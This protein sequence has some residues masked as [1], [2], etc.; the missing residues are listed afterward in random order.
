MTDQLYLYYHSV[1][2]NSLLETLRAIRLNSSQTATMLV[3]NLL[4]RTRGGVPFEYAFLEWWNAPAQCLT[5]ADALD[6]M[7]GKD[8]MD[9]LSGSLFGQQAEVRFRL[10]PY[11]P[12]ENHNK[13]SF[14]LA[15]IS[16]VPLQGGQSW[17]DDADALQ[18]WNGQFQDKT[19]LL[20]GSQ[21]HRDKGWTELQIP[22]WLAYP[23]EKTEP[24][25]GDEGVLL[26]IREYKNASGEVIA[27]RRMNLR[28]V[29]EN[30]QEISNG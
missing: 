5:A 6:E 8:P 7:S 13:P 21:Y 29:T 3:K 24:A 20:W 11:P 22:R 9:L 15:F 30:S 26:D 18:A 17:L 16:A 23:V 10:I 14:W 27:T 12:K 4:T 25:R 2:P 1:A 28:A 19:L